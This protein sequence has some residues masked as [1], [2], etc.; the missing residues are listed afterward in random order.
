MNTPLR[1]AYLIKKLEYGGAE[2][3][4]MTVARE[5]VRNGHQVVIMTLQQAEPAFIQDMEHAGI[6]VHCHRFDSPF[7]LPTTVFEI[8][9]LLQ[10]YQPDVVHSHMFHSNMVARILYPFMRKPVFV[11]TAHNIKEGSK[12]RDRLYRLT[13]GLCDVTTNVSQAAVRRYNEDGLVKNNACLLIE[14][15]IDTERFSADVGA[16]DQ[17]RRELGVE[18]KFVWLSVASLTRQKDFPNML[19]GFQ[20][21]LNSNPASHLFIAGDGP[22]REAVKQLVGKLDLAPNVT[23]LGNRKDTVSLYA[24]AD[25]FVM[26]S[27]WEGLPIVLLEALSC[28]L[29][30]VVTDVGGNRDLVVSGENGFVVPPASHKELAKAMKQLMQLPAERLC[31]LQDYGRRH[32]VKGYGIASAA[33]R[34]I[35]LYSLLIRNRLSDGVKQ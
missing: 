24:M 10:R 3:Q 12:H 32:I 23:L 5:Q 17:Y 25:G 4:L 19:H 9:R 6:P 20:D 33:K 1:I 18:D 22:E 7:H 31:S 35:D 21:V 29:P 28:S 11:C 26:S 13:D 15:G 2:M 27:S 8:H 34:W 14:N 30:C 16:R